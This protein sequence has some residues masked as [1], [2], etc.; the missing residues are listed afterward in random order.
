MMDAQPS[1]NEPSRVRDLTG[2]AP[3]AEPLPAQK[4]QNS[5]QEDRERSFV[6]CVLLLIVQVGLGVQASWPPD[7]VGKITFHG[8]NFAL[9]NAW[10]VLQT[11]GRFTLLDRLL[12]FVGL[13]AVVLVAFIFQRTDSPDVF[14]ILLLTQAFV[15]FVPLLIVRWRW[16]LRIERPAEDAIAKKPEALQFRLIHLFAWTLAAAVLLALG[17]FL[18][19]L[20]AHEPVDQYVLDAFVWGFVQ[21]TIGWT[22]CWAILARGRWVLR[23]PIVLAHGLAAGMLMGS[24]PWRVPEYYL[25]VF[26]TQAVALALGLLLFRIR[27]FQLVRTRS[28]TETSHGSTLEIS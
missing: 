3:N 2:P 8:L 9:I 28:A 7:V 24:H 10:V 12:S 1:A 27:G 22:G 21:G 26:A 16:G 11:L 15:L 19:R 18:P 20:S 5:G 13:S 23:M 6:V 17:K 14:A 4:P 25:A